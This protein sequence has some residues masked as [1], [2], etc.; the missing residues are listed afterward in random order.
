MMKQYLG[1]KERYPGCLLFFRMGDFYETFLEDAKI[2]AREL[3]LV[4]TARDKEKTVPM[5]GVPWHSVDGYL[6]KLV[7]KGYRIALCDQI[8][9]PD[10]KNLVERQ[11]VRVVTPATYLPPEGGAT[12]YLAALL[13]GRKEWALGFLRAADA[14]ISLFL[15]SKEAVLDRLQTLA[16]AELLL[17]RGVTGPQGKWRSL[18]LPPSQF[19]VAASC[20]HLCRRWNLE[21]LASF[22]LDDESPLVGVAGALLTYL[23]ETSFSESGHVRGLKQV[24]D[25]AFLSLD[26]N[27]LA[28][29]E[30]FSSPGCLYDL[31]KET[32]TAQGARKLATWLSRPSRDAA[33]LERRY[34]GVAA[35]QAMNLE[36]LRELLSRVRD[37]ERALARLH[38]GQAA[39]RDL[40]ALK[41]TLA[42]YP[43][44][45]AKAQTLPLTLPSPEN[46]AE[47]GQ[48]LAQTLAD[49]LPRSLGSG[50]LIARG[51]DSQLESW[52]A[53]SEQGDQWLEDYAQTLRETL[54]ISRLKI[55]TNRVFG[56]TLEISKAQL[57]GVTLPETFRRRQT[58]VSGERFDTPELR[59]FE[60]KR[61]RAEVEI[62]A[63]ERQIFDE[64]VE[65]ARSCTEVLQA[66]ASAL[67]TL[68]CLCAFAFL[69]L[70][71]GWVRPKLTA[72]ELQVVEGRHPLVEATLVGEPFVPFTFSLH[73][74]RRI[75]LVTGP[76]MAGKS[77][78]LRAL[79]LMCVMA[80]AGCFVPAKEAKLPLFDRIFTRVGARDELTRGRSTFMVE[81]VETAQILNGAT[82]QSLVI[83][84]EVGRGT[85]T[86]DG[87]SIAWALLEYLS[88]LGLEAPF[89]LFSTHY[90]EL[91]DLEGTLEGLFNVSI[92][93]AE[94]A[95]GP[96]FTHQ[97]VDGPA[98]KSYGVE[99]ARMAGLPRR[100]V[101]R[102]REL[103]AQLEGQSKTLEPS[104]LAFFDLEG[105][106]FAD[107]VA[108]LDPENM[109]PK[110]ALELIYQLQ[111]QAQDL[112]RKS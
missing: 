65:K 29:L 63:R 61:A 76:N 79:G 64:L 38:T 85:S 80:Q 53:V 75:A 11:V 24:T 6:A 41:E 88:Q 78:F 30:V 25:D 83:L 32:Q 107:R 23:E 104:Q 56:T 27:A 40:G 21:T 1:W 22:G 82:A 96:L 111:K 57:A 43:E 34:D 47:L 72:G 26:A 69:S 39:P 99:V 10:G 59:E 2:V 15:G 37:V 102:A 109:T 60:E 16:P 8:S 97:L 100:V 4:L 68:D 5:A 51:V 62:A 17:P 58:L 52:R 44:L 14:N 70:R 73:R 66:L 42:V 20:H 3:D 7:E 74:D 108:A 12:P 90:H 77:T 31:L 35:L 33:L 98:D 71:W 93:V 81:M 45:F 18:H 48:K 89:A 103:M 9:E 95:D 13:P 54:G 92:A 87:M 86:Y 106:R 91:T 49:P 36:E 50:E 94:G 101:A 19:E 28:H 55:S 84:D 105:D 110:E 67:A 112:R 46:L